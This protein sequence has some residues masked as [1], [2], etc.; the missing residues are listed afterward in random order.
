ML[1]D[2]GHVFIIFH[3]SEPGEEFIHYFFFEVGN[4][5]ELLEVCIITNH[6]FLHLDILVVFMVKDLKREFIRII[7]QIY[8][9][10]V[11]KEPVI[12][13]LA[14]AI[15]NLIASL[16]VF[17]SFNYKA[18]SVISVCP[19]G[20]SRPSVVEHVSIGDKTISLYAFNLNAKYPATHHHPDL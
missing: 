5:S 2:E 3:K 1:I 19:G 17:H 20:L 16:D 6:L 9:A 8:E 18:L 13:L 10:I 14:I 15:I 4:D 11:Q 7:V 12:A